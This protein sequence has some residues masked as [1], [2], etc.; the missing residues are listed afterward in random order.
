MKI[1]PRLPRYFI[2]MLWPNNAFEPTPL[3]GEQDRADFDS[4]IRL[5]S[6]LDLSVRRGSMLAVGRQF[7]GL[8]Y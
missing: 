7:A 5:T 2:L 1:S 4:W 6:I 3:C 8:S